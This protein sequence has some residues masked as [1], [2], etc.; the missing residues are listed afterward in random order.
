MR[1]HV[2][3]I[4]QR[5]LIWHP[6]ELPR[7]EGRA[8]QQN[9]SYDEENGAASLRIVFESDFGRPAGYHSADTEWFVLKGEAQLGDEKLVE[10][11]YWRAPAG[12][13]VGDLTAKEGTE[14][15]QFREYGDMGYSVSD[16]DKSDFIPMGGNTAST[17]P[18]EFTIAHSAQMEWIQN[19]PERG[20]TQQF[21]QKKDL[22]F[23]WTEGELTKGFRTFLCHAPPGWADE[24]LIHHPVFEESYCI[25]GSMT[26]NYGPIEP[27]TYFFR[28]S[29]VKHGSFMADNELGT[30]WIFRLDG[31]L[32]N[33]VTLEA[34]FKVM[35]IADNYDENDPE[36]APVI[37][38]I[39]TRSR[40]VG[41]WDGYG[42]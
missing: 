37:A 40:S 27:G 23:D 35:G 17:D 3:V 41:L 13:R 18:G 10:G 6:A 4:H 1:P 8:K 26:Y 39:P 5:D 34:A 25:G 33:W 32:L 15:L 7:G 22:F 30:T 28:P 24:R 29:H 21:L 11:D 14:I 12:L 19:K 42:R 20:L 36:Q 16:T 9:L 2:E 38:G 31:D